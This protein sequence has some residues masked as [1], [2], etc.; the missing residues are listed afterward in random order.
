MNT[1]TH[2]EVIV[3]LQLKGI[4]LVFINVVYEFLKHP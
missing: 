2:N 4:Q 3:I 1:K